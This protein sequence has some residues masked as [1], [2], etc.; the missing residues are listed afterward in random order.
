M[1]SRKRNE[2]EEEDRLAELKAY[3]LLDTPNEPAFDAIVRKA[4]STFGTPIALISLIDEERQWF[5]ARHGLAPAETPRAISFCTHAI[6]S[7]E[8]MVVED[9]TKD[10]RFAANPLVT[11]DPN[12]R[13]YAGAPL[14]TVSGRRIGTLCVIGREARGD[15]SET[16]QQRLQQMAQEVMTAVE[17]RRGRK[18]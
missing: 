3:G 13:F 1:L 17:Q 2:H 5:K 9:A 16:S 7:S 4:A 6:R 18:Q 12:I 14:K 15:F 10:E 11:G 8:V